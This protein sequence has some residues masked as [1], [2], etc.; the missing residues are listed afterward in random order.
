[1]DLY[2]LAEL[3]YIHLKISTVDLNKLSPSFRAKFDCTKPPILLVK[4]G[5]E[6]RAVLENEKIER[7][8][9]KNIPGGHLLFVKDPET[10]KLIENLYSKFKL[11]LSRNEPH[12]KQSLLRHLEAIDKHLGE[13]K[14]KFIT[15]DD[16]CCFDFELITKLQHLRIAGEYFIDQFEIPKNLINLWNYMN[17][18]YH[19]NAFIEASPDDQT[20]I[21]HYLNSNLNLAN[22]SSPAK[23]KNKTHLE[24]QKPSI[25]M[26]TP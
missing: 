21:S 26:S 15:G 19:L 20:I 10:A 24:L 14:T 1:M 16:L 6:Q 23:S 17:T 12:T 11:A 4:T 18:M 25:T 3:N 9:M 8:I 5:N 2:L 22:R 7:Y 13:R